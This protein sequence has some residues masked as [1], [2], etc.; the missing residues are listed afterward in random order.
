MET[1]IYN[2]DSKHRNITSYPNSNNYSYN[3]SEGTV[4][5]NVYSVSNQITTSS[6]QSIN[7]IEPFNE[8]NV[9]SIIIS[10][11]EIPNSFYYIDETTRDNNNLTLNTTEK[12]I[13]SG[14]KYTK[15]TLTEA[16]NTLLGSSTACT[17][18]TN[19][20][21]ITIANSTGGTIALGFLNTTNY[22]SLGQILGFTE[23]TYNINNGS[24]I[25]S[26]NC[27]KN[28]ADEY[29]FLKINDLG[30]ITN[31]NKRY[32]SKIIL[33]SDI[34]NTTRNHQHRY[35]TKE[36]K[37]NQPI[38]INKLEISIYD[39]NNN[40]ISSTQI[41]IPNNITPPVKKIP[42]IDYKLIYGIL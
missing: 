38:N 32:T 23:N 16:V 10:S 33:D 6:L 27:I 28:I 24:S 13:N 39:Y 8:E 20:N 30:N 36:I 7:K 4:I 21:K 42:K 3:I 37:F 41:D 40:L 17:L 1:V 25:T 26:E 5:D 19:T 34:F 2:I 9:E 29:V 15:Q 11:I 35:I 14:K 18:D 31:R 22:L 12:K